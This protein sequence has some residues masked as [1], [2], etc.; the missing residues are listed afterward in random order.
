MDA[1]NL[2]RG[3]VAGV[4]VDTVEVRGR[5]MARGALV[6]AVL[7]LVAAVLLDGGWRWFFVVAVLGALGAAVLVSIIRRLSVAMIHRI[8]TPEDFGDHRAAIDR[9]VDDADLPTGPVAAV[10]FAWRLRK[11]AGAETERL[12][13]IVT[14]L[15]NELDDEP[16]QDRP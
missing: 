1:E 4:L 6:I 7:G 8:G 5:S 9:A 13:A 12:T 2:A 15:R 16:D 10:R 11:D 14:A 3:L